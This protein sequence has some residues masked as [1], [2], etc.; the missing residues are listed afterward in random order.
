M[1]KLGDTVETV[2]LAIDPAAKRIGL[3]LKQALGDPWAG[4]TQKF[5][6][7]ST[8]E[9]PVVSFTK[10]GAFVQLAEGVEGMI[11]ISEITAEKRLNHPTEVL[12]IGEVVKAQVLDIDETK[13]QLKLSIKQLIPTD[14]DEFLA[15]HK[16]GDTVTGRIISIDGGNARSN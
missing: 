6:I 8:I 1:L 16:L 10:F 13:R 5:P 4:I 11:H 3:G 12:R 9:A 15:D 2:I 7:G 14:I